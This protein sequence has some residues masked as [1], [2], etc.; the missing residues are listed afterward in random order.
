MRI[1]PT[2][3]VCTVFCEAARAQDALQVRPEVRQACEVVFSIRSVGELIEIFGEP[4]AHEIRSERDPHSGRYR[5]DLHH[6]TFDGVEAFFAVTETLGPGIVWQQFKLTRPGRR[7]PPESWIGK[8]LS[9]V[10]AQ[11]GASDR[12]VDGKARYSCNET[13]EIVL[14]SK[15][16]RIS[17]VEWFGYFD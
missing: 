12:G 15:K 7:V 5:V 4:R 8:E 1:A 13:E 2:L 14:T 16:G 6:A 3:I 17:E 9:D 11:L 10:V